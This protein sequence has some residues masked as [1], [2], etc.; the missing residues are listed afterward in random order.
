MCGSIETRHLVNAFSPNR[1]CHHVYVDLP[2]NTLSFFIAIF[3][4]SIVEE[5][6]YREK[7]ENKINFCEI[8]RSI[9]D[10]F[11]CQEKFDSNAGHSAGH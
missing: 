3:V 2:H 9:F 6:L 1:S 8:E 4:W 5:S 10:V 11:G 7:E